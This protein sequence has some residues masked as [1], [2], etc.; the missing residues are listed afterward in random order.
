LSGPLAAAASDHGLG[1]GWAAPVLDGDVPRALLLLFPGAKRFPSADEQAALEAAVPL[2]Q[3]A[4]AATDL[5]GEVDRAGRVDV[6]TGVL[7]RT[8]FLHELHQLARRSR[9]VLGVMLV[10]VGGVDAINRAHGYDA[11]DAALRTIGERLARSI[12]GRD[13]VGR[14]SGTRFAVAGT[15]QGASGSFPQF[16]NRVAAI[17]HEPVTLGDAALPVQC[18]LAT[19]SRRGRVADPEAVLLEVEQALDEGAGA[20]SGADGERTDATERGNKPE[21]RRGA[22]SGSAR[23]DR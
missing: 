3:V 7:T 19:A 18:R 2:A 23:I 14:I 20:A 9:D 8:A 1:F 21:R 16:A 4:V 5:R 13:V 15:A 11:G 10:E 17:L 12:R 22:R 6:F